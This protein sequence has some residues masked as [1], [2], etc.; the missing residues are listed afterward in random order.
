MPS[1]ILL[2]SALFYNLSSNSLMNG[3]IWWVWATPRSRFSENCEF[4]WTF[5]EDFDIWIWICCI[6]LFFFFFPP[7]S[8][9]FFW[10]CVRFCKGDIFNVFDEIWLLIS[11]NFSMNKDT[12]EEIDSFQLWEIPI[13]QY[14]LMHVFL[15]FHCSRH[16]I[17]LESILGEASNLKSSE[18]CIFLLLDCYLLMILCIFQVD[19]VPSWFEVFSV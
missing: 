6:A 18:G 1:Q 15:F 14:C 11:V 8:L 19:I 4:L 13:K 7:L 2:T 5:G 17:Y 16:N 3:R 9:N 12:H 10:G